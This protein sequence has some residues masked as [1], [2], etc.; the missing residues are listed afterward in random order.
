MKMRP[1]VNEPS[2]LPRHRNRPRLAGVV[3]GIAAVLSLP[4]CE[5]S[6]RIAPD[7]AEA[8]RI[9]ERYQ[10]LED[11][12][13]AI[14]SY[15]EVLG[16]HQDFARALIARAECRLALADQST[17]TEKRRSLLENALADLERAS[18]KATGTTR[19]EALSLQGH[20]LDQLSRPEEAVAVFEQLVD[21][22]SLS[23]EQLSQAHLRIGNQLLANTVRR[24]RADVRLPLGDDELRNRCT[25][26]RYHFDTALQLSPGSLS[27]LYGKGMCLLLEDRG[28]AAEETLSQ[29]LS[30]NARLREAVR[31]ELEQLA[32]G[33]PSAAVSELVTKQL[34]AKRAALTRE[35]K[36]RDRSHL[37][38]LYFRAV[39]RERR[40]GPNAQSDRE[41]AEAL[42]RD[43]R[44]DFVLVH[45]RLLERLPV[46]TFQ[47]SERER[48][49]SDL[50]R[51]APFDEATWKSAQRYFSGLA[52]QQPID[53]LGLAVASARLGDIPAALGHLG[54][55]LEAG[56]TSFDPSEAIELTFRIPETANL[57]TRSRLL[58]ARLNAYRRVFPTGDYP[59][60]ATLWTEL[61]GVLG[62]LYQRYRDESV[63]MTAEVELHLADLCGEF[64]EEILDNV[65][66][67][68][69]GALLDEAS[70]WTDREREI[71]AAN[72]QPRYESIF[73]K[74]R[75][76]ALK[77]ETKIDYT[78]AEEAIESGGTHFTPAYLVVVEAYR[79]QPDAT[80]ERLEK[81]IQRYTGE[82][83]VVRSAQQ[84]IVQAELQRAEAEEQ[85]LARERE[86]RAAQRARE[87]EAKQYRVC[88][89]CKVRVAKGRS[90]CS[91]GSPLPPVT[92]EPSG[93]G[94]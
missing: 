75:I 86:E 18:A 87:E 85:R 54:S 78:I 82:D 20:L 9:A 3:L 50:L 49:V 52:R 29:A 92:D 39:A 83:S 24:H 41:Y 67:E 63:E 44:H 81:L 16:Q 61:R 47:E 93:G 22:S 15:D 51:F 94:R 4:A 74:G 56:S 60:R 10:Q 64:A 70:V 90:V 88:P 76:K 77:N 32:S 11:Y 65:E 1:R 30:I 55:L 14:E 25:R 27:A 80:R 62:K 33:D 5:S 68:S 7:A 2:T 13:L 35:L 91:C 57:V 59:T 42:H 12:E 58:S 69:H 21:E 45:R 23:Q 71:L 37:E 36:E 79:A 84:Q 28:S 43:E 6:P 40:L 72:E 53:L 46:A 26:A 31:A 8:Y 73:R 48:V 66:L 34:E 19:V 89:V 38:A 17:E